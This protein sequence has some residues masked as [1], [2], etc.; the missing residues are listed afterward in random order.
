[1][2][3]T[4]LPN[5]FRAMLGIG[6]STLLP[7]AQVSAGTVTWDGDSS[8]SWTN[9]A[10][11]VGNA[12]PTDGDDVVFSSV[13]APT[14]NPTS[15]GTIPTTV[16]GGFR[17]ITFN[18]TQTSALTVNGGFFYL[19]APG[20]GSP[21]LVHSKTSSNPTVTLSNT[22]RFT[23][24]QIW[25]ID[26]GAT[27]VKDTGRL[28][29]D[30][31]GGS[32]NFEKTGGGT[33]RLSVGTAGGDFGGA[34][35][36]IT[37]TGGTVEITVASIDQ[38]GSTSNTIVFNGGTL[39]NTAGGAISQDRAMSVTS[40]GGTMNTGA[41]FNWTQN[42]SIAFTGNLTK[43]GAQA[44]VIQGASANTGTGGMII[45]A[46]TVTM[47]KADGTNALVGDTNVNSGGSLRWVQ[48]NQIADTA[49]VVINS[50]GTLD[51]NGKVET[52]NS[53]SVLNGANAF[54]T[55]AGAN[56]E[57]TGNL[58]LGTV[59][60]TVSSASTLKGNTLNVAGATLAVGGATTSGRLEAGSGGLL[61]SAGSITL[62]N[63]DAGGELRLGG[64]ATINSSATL[65][66]TNN[67][68]LGA[69]KGFVNL[70]AADRTFTVNH[71]AGAQTTDFRIST[72]VTGTGGL[73][74]AGN[75]TMVLGNEVSPTT[76]DNTYTGDTTVSAG[77]LVLAQSAS[78]L[79]N[80]GASGVNNGIDGSGT[81]TLNGRFVFDLTGASTS[82]GSAWN[83]VNV[84][85][86]SETFGSTFSVDTFTDAGSGLWTKDINGTNYYQFSEL[87]G[88]LTVVPEP[89]TWALLAGALTFLVV[90]RR[91]RVAGL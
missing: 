51:L 59:T 43:T 79:F 39:A 61:F 15:S 66:V 87:S 13:A 56:L 1:M 91:R 46:G 71:V 33:L 34:G 11:W 75:G 24:D 30:G 68:G 2:K 18:N 29:N 65:I 4:Y 36:N 89:T 82:F 52:L 20:G 19:S 58:N 10:N 47:N 86:L 50:G 90:F 25:Q 9:A 60:G 45:N 22:I 37:L 84:G 27:L 62:N 74:K 76:I 44:F 88:A 32:V 63:G 48:N 42:G 77:T 17:S 14:N 40:N 81:L 80:I 57:T 69:V 12:V 54:T 28:F 16:T 3:N 6:L 64:D 38:L 55:G 53:L 26:T 7:L 49:S 23:A 85:S 72:V 31:V 73:V 67:G 78:L 8:T 70:G 5:A 35:K 83:I 41:S 21:S